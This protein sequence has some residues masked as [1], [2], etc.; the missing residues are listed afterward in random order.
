ML[1]CKAGMWDAVGGAC[2]CMGRQ[3]GAGG[4]LPITRKDER[5]GKALEKLLHW[6]WLLSPH[7]FAS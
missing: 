1:K 2:S 4:G 5:T 3:W 6:N 7:L